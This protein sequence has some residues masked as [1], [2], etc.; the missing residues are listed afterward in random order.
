MNKRIFSISCMLI[1][2]FLA[3]FPMINAEEKLE[4]PTPLFNKMALAHIK[5]DGN[6]S[7]LIIAGE[8]VVGFGRCAYIRFNLDDTSHIEINKFLDRTNQVELDGSHVITIFGFVGY[9]RET[10]VSINLN[11]FTALVFW[12]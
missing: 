10:D 8:F 11:G 7:S 5:I 9:Y 3:A 2:I 4:A 6:G 12:R 1:F